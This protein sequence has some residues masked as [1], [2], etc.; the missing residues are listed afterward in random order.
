VVKVAYL[1]F[2]P[3]RVIRI[4]VSTVLPKTH[5]APDSYINVTVAFGHGDGMIPLNNIDAIHNKLTLNNIAQRAEAY[6]PKPRTTYKMLQEYILEKYSFKVHTAYIAE[7]K[8][9][10]GLQMYDAPNAVKTLKQPRKHPTPI[11]VDAIKEALTYFEVI[12][13]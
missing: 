11:Q 4:T 3:Q 10:L 1:L 13:N 5:K 9:G 6:K 2:L 7:V 12:Q 8:R